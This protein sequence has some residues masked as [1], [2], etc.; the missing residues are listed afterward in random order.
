M[1]KNTLSLRRHLT[2]YFDVKIH[3]DE[4]TYSRYLTIRLKRRKTLS[5]LRNN[6]KNHRTMLLRYLAAF[7]EQRND[8]KK[9][10]NLSSISRLLTQFAYV[11]SEPEREENTRRV[12][13]T[14]LKQ[15]LKDFTI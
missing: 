7:E 4:F 10:N 12:P 9:K 1:I 13:Y 8:W 6:Y 15:K 5:T 14:Q 2:R 3:I 11:A